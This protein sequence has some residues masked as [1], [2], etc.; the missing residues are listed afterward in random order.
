M[1]LSIEDRTVPLAIGGAMVA[2]GDGTYP[3]FNPAHPDEVVLVAPAASRG[4][5]D[6]AVAG[7]RSAQPSWAALGFDAQVARLQ[8]ACERAV[9]T[10]DLEATS[11]RLTREHGKIRMEALWDLATT[12]RMVG[13]LPSLVAESP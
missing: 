8:E 2:G 4:Q 9:E 3:V 6:A 5:L 13:P 1:A 11:D 7:A 10:I 12:P